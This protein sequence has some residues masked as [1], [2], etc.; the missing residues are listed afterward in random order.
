MEGESREM[1]KIGDIYAG[2]P[3][4]GDEIKECG[5]EEFANIFI[6]PTGVNIGR[7]AST[8]YGTPF[9]I[10]GD[11]GT[12]KT[13]L[14]HFLEKHVC[15]LDSSACTSFICFE[16]DFP[17]PQ[18]DKMEMIS[19]SLFTSVTIDK[20]I[21]SKGENV[22]CDFSYIW[23]WQLYQKLIDDNEKFNG[24]LFDA[25]S[26]WNKF[27]SEINK[28]NK[29]ID[30]GKMFLP[31]KI[32]LSATT[33]QMAGTVTQGI[34]IEPLDLSQSG[35][36][37]TKSYGEFVKVINNADHYFSEVKR[38]DVPFYI[39]IDELEAYRGKQ[40]SFYRDLRMI[41]DLLFTVKNLN[42]VLG[43]GTKIIC[44]VRPEILNAINRFVESKQL[45][46]IMQG[47]DERLT[48]E[49][50]NTNSF[51][52][53]IIGVLLR[54]IQ[55]AEE[56]NDNNSITE[57]KI[58]NK[59]FVPQV[60][61][62]H[63]CT[64]ILD[65]TWHKPRDIVRMLLAAQSKNSREFTIFNQ[66]TFE[67]F[68]PAYSKQCLIE[69]R[70]EMHALYTA[71]EIEDI[72]NCLQGFKKLFTFEEIKKRAETMFPASAFATD[73]LEVLRDM[74]RAGVVGNYNSINKTQLWAH[75]E[76]YNLIIGSPWQI[77]IHPSLRIELSVGGRTGRYSN[78]RIQWNKEKA[79]SSN[80]TYDVVIMKIQPHHMLV[81]FEKD[82]VPQTGYISM[83]HLSSN[84]VVKCNLGTKFNI[85]ETITAQISGYSDKH[86]NWY[87]RIKE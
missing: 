4:A 80:E 45:H 78:D 57:K 65:N 40:P 34:K 10:M 18:R 6:H 84:D 2:K 55:S 30:K 20:S 75:K 39:F 7:L 27:V 16:R 9:F 60:Y 82:G 43:N 22:E 67:T 32:T 13:A 71:E 86:K 11:K 3:D 53:P 33:N 26:A 74:Y 31:A 81:S 79:Y 44:S 77:V 63:I 73:T 58:I 19:Q 5:Y 24:G 56:K 52:H 29:T 69:V 85:G 64:Y 37:A 17:K 46:K 51:S 87:M 50:T 66:N 70:E 59:W 36:Q 15:D 25:N 72:F 35:F 42:G 12:G 47:Y 28:T 76:Q 8:T 38:T 1:L 14:L 54:R 49:H 61:N 23:R 83:K 21:T 48:W 41:R 68:M 62:K